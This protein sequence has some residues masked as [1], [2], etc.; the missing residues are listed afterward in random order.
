MKKIKDPKWIS[1]ADR[2]YSGLLYLFPSTH[3]KEFGPWM[4]QAFRDRCREVARGEQR[5]FR[6]LAVEIVPDLLLGAGR[7]HMTSNFGELNRKHLAALTL[8]GCMSVWAL[9]HE[10]VNRQL[11]DLADATKRKTADMKA[12]YRYKKYQARTEEMAQWLVLEEGSPKAKALAAYLYLTIDDEKAATL[13][14]QV[15]LEHPDLRTLAMAELS[16]RESTHCNRPDIV[17][18]LTAE[19]PNNAY[20]WLRALNGAIDAKDQVSE[21]TALRKMAASS[22]MEPYEAGIEKE[23]IG[24]A[25]RFAPD[26]VE[27]LEFLDARFA[28]ST[29]SAPILALSKSQCAALSVDTPDNKLLGDCRKITDQFTQ[30]DDLMTTGVVARLR[31]RLSTGRE[32]QASAYQ[33]LLDFRWW[34]A[35]YQDVPSPNELAS[36]KKWYADWRGKRDSIAAIKSSLMSRGMPTQAPADFELSDYDRA[37]LGVANIPIENVDPAEFSIQLPSQTL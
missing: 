30:T 21:R 13:A 24:Y 17:A 22:H 8:L 36:W 7:E 16:C 15:A 10:T 31:Y 1:Q 20:V 35:A 6:V 37:Q 18:R 23:L 32:E 33:H 2:F 19:D 9:F 34:Q 25:H 12:E 29:P 11:F 14:Q 4:R 28:S 5:L 27:I 26:D 3:R